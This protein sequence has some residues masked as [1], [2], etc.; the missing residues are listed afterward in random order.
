MYGT[1]EGPAPFS[2]LSK[3]SLRTSIYRSPNLQLIVEY[4]DERT[5]RLSTIAGSPAY[6]NP[7]YL[8]GPEREF[9]ISM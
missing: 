6:S 8:F 7:S 3:H 5:Y 1:N 9:L 2:F 4:L